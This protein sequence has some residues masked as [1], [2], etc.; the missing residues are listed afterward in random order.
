M[1]PA[2]AQTTQ[3][4]APGAFVVLG[5]AQI[6]EA[7]PPDAAPS[8]LRERLEAAAE[9]LVDEAL[10]R[11]DG[12]RA[13]TFEHAERFRALVVRAA[14]RRMSAADVYR[15]FGRPGA[16]AQNNHQRLLRE[17][18]ESADELLRHLSGG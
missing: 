11:Q 17:Q 13:L 5:R 16:V 9:A 12:P 14:A 8:A 7:L 10:K 4:I 2:V 15:L 18:L 1:R 6:Q 3:G